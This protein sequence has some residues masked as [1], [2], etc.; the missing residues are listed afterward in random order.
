MVTLWA[1]PKNRTRNRILDHC[2][3]GP[4]KKR[5]PW[6]KGH[7]GLQTL[8]FA[9]SHMKDNFELSQFHVKNKASLTCKKTSR[10]TF[11]KVYYNFLF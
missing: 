3:N 9:L 8:P 7:R 1:S 10:K 5:T 2:K 11:E 6:K 4:F